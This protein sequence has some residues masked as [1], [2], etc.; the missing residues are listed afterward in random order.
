MANIKDQHLASTN[1]QYL[2]AI[3]FIFDCTQNVTAVLQTFVY[4]LPSGEGRTVMVDVVTS[5]GS[6]WVKVITRKRTAIHR[7]WLGEY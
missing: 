7:K 2:E 4:L 6:H 5:K 1:L 3:Q